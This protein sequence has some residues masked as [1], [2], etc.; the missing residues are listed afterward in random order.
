[1]DFVTAVKN[2]GNQIFF[3]AHISLPWFTTLDFR[4]GFDDDISCW[5]AP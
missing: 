1:M 2:S 5:L 4:V 3:G